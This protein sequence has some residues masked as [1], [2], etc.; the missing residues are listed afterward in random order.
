MHLIKDSMQAATGRE[1]RRGAQCKKEKI[2]IAH[3]KKRTIG[4]AYTQLVAQSVMEIT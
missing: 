1:A 4:W 3:L 2:H